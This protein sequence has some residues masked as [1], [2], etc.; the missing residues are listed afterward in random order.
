MRR[1]LALLLPTT[2]LAAC[3]SVVPEQASRQPVQRSTQLYSARPEA[4]ACLAS[5]GR[6][7]AG[8]TPLPDQYCGAHC[9]TLDR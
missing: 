8:F 1:R 9:A 5:R 4:G 7:T 3:G 2:L 6:T